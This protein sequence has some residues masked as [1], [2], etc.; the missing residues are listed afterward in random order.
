MAPRGSKK[1]VALVLVSFALCATATATVEL[2]IDVLGQNNYAL[3]RGKRVG[4]VT[5]QTGVDARGN[6]TRVLLKQNCNL[7]ALYTP[8]HGLDGREKAGRYVKSRRDP[9]TGLTAYSLYGPTRK[10]TPSMLRGIDVLVFDIQDIG[11]RSYSYISTMGKCM[12]AAA[13]NNIDFVVLDRPNPLGGMR[14]EGPL[15]ERPWISFV[16]QYPIPYVH[17]MTVGELAKM[18]NGEGWLGGR[19]RLT[20]VPMSGWTRDLTWPETG[21]R[22]IPTSPNIPRAMSPFY[23]V[24]TGMVGELSGVETGVGGYGPFEMIAAK[25]LNAAKFTDYLRSLYMP[26]VFFQ[27]FHRG[28][29]QGT[30][31]RI[32]PKASADLTGLGVYMLGEINRA[33]GFT[34]FRQTSRSKL[35]LFFKVYGSSAIRSQLEQGESP[36]SIVGS[37]KVNVLRFRKERAAYLI[38]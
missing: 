33:S 29:Q 32:D 5:N 35:N 37:W 21:L 26:G 36:S 4:L 1:S 31:L 18:I 11:C 17:G 13:E 14:V 30:L 7:V 9:L 27:E 3:L 19:C 22:W 24:A 16:S 8:E 34:F 6:R 25:W 23:Y 15:V 12:E 28:R 20:V 38:Y 10:P 2:G